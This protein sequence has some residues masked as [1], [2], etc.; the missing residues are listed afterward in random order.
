L[1]WLHGGRELAMIRSRKHGTP[2]IVMPALGRR[3]FGARCI[4]THG[5]SEMHIK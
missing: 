3:V 1:A 2:A 5:V 4:R